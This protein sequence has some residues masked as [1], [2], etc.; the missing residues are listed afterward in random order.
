MSIFLH[1]INHFPVWILEKIVQ[2]YKVS[3]IRDS[4][5]RNQSLKP[6]SLGRWE[7]KDAVD[8]PIHFVLSFESGVVVSG[9]VNFQQVKVG[10]YDFL[11]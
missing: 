9:Q 8:H 6:G 10:E 11:F 3:A 2:I 4:I 1:Q 7:G 5:D